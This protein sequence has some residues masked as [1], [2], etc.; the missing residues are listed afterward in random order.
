MTLRTGLITKATVKTSRRLLVNLRAKA[1]NY[2][3]CHIAAHMLRLS[4]FDSRGHAQ[5]NPAVYPSL[6]K[7]EGRE[8]ISHYLIDDHLECTSHIK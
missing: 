4:S 8:P 1:I 6:Y 7:A 5:Y 2:I 3:L